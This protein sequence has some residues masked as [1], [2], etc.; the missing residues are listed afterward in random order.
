MLRAARSVELPTSCF[1]WR[2]VKRTPPSLLPAVYVSPVRKPTWH[3][4][5]P[6]L[7]TRKVTWRLG[8]ACD[9]LASRTTTVAALNMDAPAW[10]RTR[11]RWMPR[12]CFQVGLHGDAF[13]H[14]EELTVLAVHR[15]CV[16]TGPRRW[17][18]VVHRDS[19]LCGCQTRKG[20]QVVVPR[21]FAVV[22]LICA[23]D[24]GLRKGTRARERAVAF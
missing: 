17:S 22:S 4:L 16:V 2:C 5:V 6:Q 3:G 8:V 23:C 14:S 18:F 21:R 19:V 20:A 1:P 10:M 15:K 13:A 7:A 11:C 24:V 9:H 12:L